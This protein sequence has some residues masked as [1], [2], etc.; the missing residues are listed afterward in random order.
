MA[1]LPLTSTLIGHTKQAG[2]L[3]FVL[4][5]CVYQSEWRPHSIRMPSLDLHEVF[6][7]TGQSTPTIH[8]SVT[9]RSS[10]TFKMGDL[11]RDN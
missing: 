5:V 6:I 1:N 7:N 9:L 8:Q 2:L 10:V 3:L 11:R 4:P